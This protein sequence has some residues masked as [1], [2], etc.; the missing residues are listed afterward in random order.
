LAPRAVQGLAAATLLTLSPGLYAS[1]DDTAASTILS[2]DTDLLE[3]SLNELAEISVVSA[4]LAPQRLAD[5][6]ASVTVIT[7]EQIARMAAR[8]LYDVLRHVPGLRVDITNRGRPVV[9]IRGVRRDSSNQLLFMLDGHR[10]NEAHN[11]SATFLFEVSDLPLD[12]IERIEVIRGPASTL[13]GSNAFLGVVNIIS[14][15]A[16]EIDGAE[17]T[18]RVEAERHGYVGSEVNL[19]Y[20]DTF[21]PDRSLSA[22]LN[23]SDKSGPRIPVDADIAG[24]SGFADKDFQQLDLQLRG[25]AGPFSVKARYTDQDRDESHGALFQLSPDGTLRFHGGFVELDAEFA[26]GEHTRILARTFFDYLKTTAHIYEQPRGSIPPESPSYPFNATGNGGRLGFDTRRFG[27]ELRATDSR[28]RNHAITYGVLWEYQAQDSF[29][30]YTNDIGIGRPVYPLVDVSATQNFGRAANRTL[31]APYIEDIWQVTED[32]TVNLGARLDYYSDFGDTFNPRI[33]LTWRAH[34]KATVRALYGT[35]FRAPDFRS[36]FLESPFF[37]GNPDLQEEKVRTFEL[38]LSVNPI[39]PLTTRLTLFDNTL[40]QLIDVPGNIGRFENIGSLSTRGIE[41]EASWRWQNGASVAASYTYTDAEFGDGSRAPDEPRNTASL[42]G[43]APV[44]DRFSVGMDVYWQDA[45]PRTG[46]DP[47][48]DLSGYTVLNLNLAYRVTDAVQLGLAAY[49]LAD[50]DYA[51]PAP[52]GTIP[53]DYR[54]AGRSLR[55]ELRLAF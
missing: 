31:V 3:L 8:D 36:L 55:A 48:R 23:L 1:I 37:D 45:S 5:S 51:L 29:K 24:R 16:A 15:D 10:L 54:A 18:F 30:V 40:E 20:G 35:A 11:G 25:E 43:W 49:N 34:P 41:L 46:G 4:S 27:A 32:L 21:G 19:L 53:G 2:D 13:F 42:I 17:A 50:E 44:T 39:A 47:R 28:F 14:R 26:A 38:G 52:A 22:N 33:G 7:A 6:P 9:T 12:N